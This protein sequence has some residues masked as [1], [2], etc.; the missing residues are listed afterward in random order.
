[1]IAKNKSFAKASP[2]RG[3]GKAVALSRVY[4]SLRLALLIL[5]FVLR[6]KMI[7]EP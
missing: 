6:Q 1:M 3:G 4:A 5:D 2:T 7:L